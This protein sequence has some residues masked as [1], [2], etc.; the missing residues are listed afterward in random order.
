MNT[1]QRVLARLRRARRYVSPAVTVCLELETA[2][3]PPTPEEI[4]LCQPRIE[5][6]VART[7]QDLAS[8]RQAAQALQRMPA[9][10]ATH[11]PVGF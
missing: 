9:V 8:V 4:L 3:P 11:A 6:A 10:P 2:Q 1:Q 7:R 5:A